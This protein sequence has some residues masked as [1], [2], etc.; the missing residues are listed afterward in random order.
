MA[1]LSLLRLPDCEKK[2]AICIDVCCRFRLIK[3]QN[4]VL[5][6]CVSCIFVLIFKTSFARYWMKNKT[7]NDSNLKTSRRESSSWREEGWPVKWT[8]ETGCLSWS[9]LLKFVPHGPLIQ[10]H[11]GHH[12][13]HQDPAKEGI[14]RPPNQVP[15]P[16]ILVFRRD[17]YFGQCLLFTSCYQVKWLR[18]RTLNVI[19]KSF[20]SQVVQILWQQLVTQRLISVSADPVILSMFM[21]DASWYETST[22]CVSLQDN[23]QRLRASALIM[24]EKRLS[25]TTFLTWDPHLCQLFTNWIQE[26]WLGFASV[27][28]DYFIIKIRANVQPES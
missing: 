16:V 7:A 28:K 25:P 14:T 8:E 19:I 6:S 18:R 1:W 27:Q 24:Q 5:L 12:H 22:N 4:R 3:L 10:P 15:C 2:K 20:Q 13:H 9:L 17:K 26:W 23:V 11:P 21:E